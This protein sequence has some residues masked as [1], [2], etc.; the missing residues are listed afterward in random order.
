MNRTGLAGKRRRILRWL[1]DSLPTLAVLITL[2]GLAVWG[3]STGWNFAGLSALAGRPHAV[4]DDWCGDH[5]VQE[6]QCV[7]C[8]ASLLPRGK[9]FGWC[10]KHGIPECPLE[11]PEVAQLQDIPRV[12]PADLQRAERALFFAPRPENNSKCKHHRRRIQFATQEAVDKAGIEP[13][14]VEQAPIIEAITANGEVTYDQVHFAR[15]SSRLPGTVWHVTKQVGDPV[16]RGEVLAL[17]DAAEVGRAKAEFLQALVHLDLKSTALASLRQAS[18]A[19]P[20]RQIVE[21]EAALRETEIRLQTAEQALVNLGLPVQAEDFKGL[22]SEESRR[23]V[24]LLGLPQDMVA[25]LEPRRTTT[26][27][28]PVVA[29]LDGIVV[30][31]EVV[32]GEVVDSTKLLFVVADVRRM[33]L[34]LSLRQEDASRVALGQKVRFR[35]DGSSEESRGE[36]RW[37]STAVDDKTRTLKVRADLDNPGGRLRA[38]MFGQG[39][40]ILREEKNALV[41]PSEAVHWEGDCHVVFVRDKHYFVEGSPKV[42][43]VRTVRPGA[44]DALNTEIIAGLLPGE[45][46]VTKGSSSLRAA[47]LKGN[48]GE[49]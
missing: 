38:N 11:H 49:G 20:E 30:N 4:K 16:Q 45:L 18:G 24:Q 35:P 43:H 13:R 46:V 29:P 7:E 5:G 21:M 28:L 26:S 19:V 32:A 14:R 48:M 27:L 25:R 1:V 12:T 22:S 23:R 17:V 8:Q 36:I 10:K 41:V 39:E 34:T 40:I 3:H 33:W 42:F 44:R 37:I 9:E 31:R 47:L 2:G 15:L 6:S